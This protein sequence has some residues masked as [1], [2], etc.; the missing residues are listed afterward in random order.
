M[1]IFLARYDSLCYNI[2]VRYPCSDK[3][4]AISPGEEVHTMRDY[5]LLYI[6]KPEVAED[7]IDGIVEKIQWYPGKRR[8]NCS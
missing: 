2:K 8:R 1:K 4:R 5:E 3:V 7:A 6:I